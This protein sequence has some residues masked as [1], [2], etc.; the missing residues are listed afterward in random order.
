MSVWLPLLLLVPA[1]VTAATS[2]TRCGSDKYELKSLG[3]CCPL[4]PA[5]Q[6]VS[7]HCD[8]TQSTQCSQCEP[9]TFTA[10]PNSETSCLPCAQCRDDQEEVTLCSPTRDRQCQCK[11]GSYYCDTGDCVEMCY[12]CTSLRPEVRNQGV[13]GPRSLG[14]PGRTLPPLPALGGGRLYLAPHGL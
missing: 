13:A 8:G 11:T 6:Y 5:G 7:K 12:R 9:G 4:C 10:H 3:L 2:V 14:G 1:S